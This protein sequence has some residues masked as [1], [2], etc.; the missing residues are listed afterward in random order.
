MRCFVLGC[1]LQLHKSNEV[2]GDETNFEAG[3]YQL[4]KKNDNDKR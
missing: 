4:G 1:F 2:I 3:I